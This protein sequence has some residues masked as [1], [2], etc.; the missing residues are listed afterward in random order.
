MKMVRF[1]RGC[2]AVAR[3]RAAQRKLTTQVVREAYSVIEQ[4]GTQ[5]GIFDGALKVDRLTIAR[6][7]ARRAGLC[8]AAGGRRATCLS[9]WPTYDSC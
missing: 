2:A 6:T 5:I 3:L 9:S 7:G 4:D 8:A 1:V